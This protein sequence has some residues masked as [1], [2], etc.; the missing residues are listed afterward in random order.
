MSQLCAQSISRLCTPSSGWFTKA[1]PPMIVPFT[2]TK[3]V[4]NGK[5]KGLS[6]A[7]YDVSIAHDLTLG[8]NPAWIIERHVKKYG[9]GKER[10]LMEQL[11]DNEPS[12]ALAHTVE[13]F[14]MPDNVAGY[15]CDKSSFARVFVTAF[16]T[17]FDPGFVGNATLELVNLGSYPVH[18]KAG[19][20]VCQFVFHWLDRTTDRPYRGK[21]QN[22]ARK[23]QAAIYE[24]G[25]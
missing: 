14:H 12:A 20:P 13:D 5:S 3:I 22:Q 9:L 2:P 10:L 16:N 18:Y 4:V 11:D 1:K 8:V 6:A 15:V 21:Y 24:G 19:D 17:L 7:S 25:K 23:P